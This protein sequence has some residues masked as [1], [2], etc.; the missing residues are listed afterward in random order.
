MASNQLQEKALKLAVKAVEHDRN[1]EF[2]FAIFFYLV[3]VF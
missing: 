1:A 2:E 3:F